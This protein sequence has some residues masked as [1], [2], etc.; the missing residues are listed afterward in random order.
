MTDKYDLHT[1]TT[2]SD[3][4]LEP[5]ELI[6]AA[7]KERLKG[8]SI[9]DH[10]TMAAYTPSLVQ[11][12]LQQDIDL[13]S[14]IEISS[15]YEGTSVHVLGYDF[16]LNA[17]PLVEL[18][19]L[20]RESR[21]ARNIQIIENLQAEGIPITFTEVSEGHTHVVGRPHIARLLIEKNI[22]SSMEEAFEKYLSDQAPCYVPMKGVATQEAVE[23]VHAAQGKAFLAHPHFFR[24][25]QFVKDLLHLG[26]DGIECYYAK[27]PRMTNERYIRLAHRHD[28]LIS[29]GS[30]FH[31]E[32]KPFNEL[33]CAYIEK[34]D[35]FSVQHPVKSMRDL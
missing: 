7:K 30:D 4:Q 29:G 25:Y 2:C 28:L 5:Q 35:L 24:S 18:I 11:Y 6:D 15:F 14:G 34:K 26:F 8:L 27:F 23:R 1:H 19:T 20:Q 12:A 21:L 3:G 10:D 16:L 17:S 13:I 31:G 22:V 32:N 33:G 9:T